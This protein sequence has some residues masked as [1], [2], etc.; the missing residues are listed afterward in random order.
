MKYKKRDE[1]VNDIKRHEGLMLKPYVCPMGKLSIG[2]GRNLD[3]NG[4]SLQEAEAMLKSD[5]DNAI[6][7]C[8]DN[9]SFFDN[10]PIP[11]QEVLI[12]MCFQMGIGSLLKFR[13]TLVYLKNKQWS[14]ASVEMLDSAWH[15]QTP[16]RAR[17]LS[18]RI[19]RLGGENV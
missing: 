7:G 13:K 4:I 14:E 19:K 2:Y 9:I 18:S 6:K 3:D 16:K 12:N 17:E 1:L 11:A 15:K 10:L 8:R 5:I